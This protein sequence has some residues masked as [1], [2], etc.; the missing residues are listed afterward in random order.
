M[1][2]GRSS[3][4]VGLELKSDNVDDND[5]KARNN[6][7]LFKKANTNKV[8]D[9]NTYDIEKLL[10]LLSYGKM[11][12]LE[13]NTYGTRKSNI[14]HA[15]DGAAILNMLPN[16]MNTEDKLET[17]ISAYLH[18]LSQNKSLEPGTITEVYDENQDKDKSSSKIQIKT[19]KYFTFFRIEHE[20][21]DLMRKSS[22]FETTRKSYL[23]K[24][25]EGLKDSYAELIRQNDPFK[26]SEKIKKLKEYKR[27][28]EIARKYVPVQKKKMGKEAI[29]MAEQFI[30]DSRKLTV[31][32]GMG[33][34]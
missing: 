34:N 27:G 13:M 4:K 22:D 20:I 14:F 17:S 11:A 18:N 8:G 1:K 30:N 21:S 2:K 6:L 26:T 9:K 23:E 15:G 31:T 3:L 7:L 28:L 5:F 33:F 29:T 32:K 16:L 12:T 10:P 19:N 24:K 25:S